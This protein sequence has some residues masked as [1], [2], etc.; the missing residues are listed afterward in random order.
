MPQKK[1]KIP[2]MKNNKIKKLFKIH[3][4]YM[5]KVYVLFAKNVEASAELFNMC[6]ISEIVFKN[7]P[8]LI[9]P[10]DEEVKKEFSKLK[11]LFVPLSQIMRI[12]EMEDVE[13]D[14]ISDPRA[15]KNR[16]DN[17]LIRPV[18]FFGR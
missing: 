8:N 14:E 7:S 18:E 4:F 3:F 10:S 12:D 6:V 17:N 2:N 16:G 13:E 15:L 11:K 5:G 9:I 1:Q